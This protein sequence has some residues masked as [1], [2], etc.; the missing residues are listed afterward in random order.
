MKNETIVILIGLFSIATL[1][2]CVREEIDTCE[3]FAERLPELEFTG[4][5]HL[6]NA[7][8]PL[9]DFISAKVR[10]TDI[11]DNDLNIKLFSDSIFIDTIFNYNYTCNIYEETIPSIDLFDFNG[12]K[13][14]GVNSNP[15]LI[16]FNFPYNE[17]INNTFFKGIVME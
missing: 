10:I 17:C 2:S 13:I 12:D 3:M 5:I 14:G 1:F 4:I 11:N 15:Y 8:P 16:R 6:C 9:M 7:Q